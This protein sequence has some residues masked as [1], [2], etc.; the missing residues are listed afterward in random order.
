MPATGTDNRYWLA[1][2]GSGLAGSLN[3]GTGLSATVS[4][5]AV[6]INTQGGKD[7]GGNP[8][9]PLNWAAAFS[10]KVNPIGSL[11]VQSTGDEFTVTGTLTDLNID[12]ALNLSA[13]FAVS[14]Q[15]VDARV[16]GAT[17]TGATLLT[18]G[19]SG[20]TAATSSGGFGI[21]VGGGSIGL[22]ILEPAVPASGTDSRYWLAVVASGLSGSLSL[23]GVSASVQGVS[24]AINTQGGTDPNNNPAGPLNWTTFSPAVSPISGLTV[25]LT[26]DGFSVTGR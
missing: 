19:L 21:S 22:A 4:G 9:A 7:S 18:I 23:G 17:L 10:P 15:T 8:A 2:V 20:V 25:K 24:V 11:M 13:T 14:D 1:V 26:G 16:G 12:N 6:A 3:L 5:L